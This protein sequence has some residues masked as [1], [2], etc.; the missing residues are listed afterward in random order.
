MVKILRL[1]FTWVLLKV[2]FNE[3][4]SHSYLQS[5][6]FPQKT[7]SLFSRSEKASHSSLVSEPRK[8]N[9]VNELMEVWRIRS[10]CWEVVKIWAI[11]KHDNFQTCSIKY[12]W[13]CFYS[14]AST[15]LFQHMN[16]FRNG[17]TCISSNVFVKTFF[18]MTYNFMRSFAM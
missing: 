18:F 8:T 1:F 15:W 2:D 11:G 3:K 16:Q 13:F 12:F 10:T 9:F 14:T 5:G 17:K 4:F 7:G 6:H